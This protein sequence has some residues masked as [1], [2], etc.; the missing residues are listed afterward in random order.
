M[1]FTQVW[2]TLEILFLGKINWNHR[3]KQHVFLSWK[4]KGGYQGRGSWTWM[5][6]E[7]GGCWEQGWSKPN[8]FMSEDDYITIIYMTL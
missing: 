4:Q 8:I 2:V 3:D 5:R 6:A 1:T 7:R